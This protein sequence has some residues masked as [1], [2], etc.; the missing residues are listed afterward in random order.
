[1]TV[2]QIAKIVGL[3]KPSIYEL[4]K[5]G[6]LKMRRFS[7]RRL[8]IHVDDLE[9][10]VNGAKHSNAATIKTF[11]QAGAEEIEV[12]NRKGSAHLVIDVIG[13]YYPMPSP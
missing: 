4:I 7:S 5:K 9:R 13:Y 8:T 3:S 11:I 1:L 2:R 6:K 12:I 10:F